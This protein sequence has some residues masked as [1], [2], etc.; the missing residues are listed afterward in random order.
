[1]TADY[2]SHPCPDCRRTAWQ[3]SNLHETARKRPACAPAVGFN[4]KS[5]GSA[6]RPRDADADRCAVCHEPALLSAP[7]SPYLEQLPSLRS[8]RA[9]PSH[10]CPAPSTPST[11]FDPAAVRICCP[12]VSRCGSLCG[13]GWLQV[14]GRRWKG[15]ARSW[16]A[17]SRGDRDRYDGGQDADQGG[18]EQHR[19]NFCGCGTDLHPNA[20]SDDV[21]I[22]LTGAHW[23]HL[24]DHL[25]H[26]ACVSS[27]R[28]SVC[29]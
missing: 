12:F 6:T 3:R 7:S 17:S 14:K 1:M 18:A 28:I 27:R 16:W 15:G 26:L 25:V 10:P 29:F 5:F 9:T 19:Q 2:C 4:S 20:P 24:L 13:F 11:P 8:L 23:H 22:D 21:W